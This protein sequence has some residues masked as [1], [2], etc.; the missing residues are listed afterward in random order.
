[1]NMPSGMTYQQSGCRWSHFIFYQPTAA[2]KVCGMQFVAMA[3]SM[4]NYLGTYLAGCGCNWINPYLF[5]VKLDGWRVS[6][7]MTSNWNRRAKMSVKKM[8]AL[9]QILNLSFILRDKAQDDCRTARGRK[10][11][12]CRIF[13]LMTTSQQAATCNLRNLNHVEGTS[14]AG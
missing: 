2:E 6:T 8:D 4:H 5:C 14:T 12:R 11:D 10:Q 13:E 7:L 9:Q 1:M 3:S